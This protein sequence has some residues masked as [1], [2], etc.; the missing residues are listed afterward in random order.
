LYFIK[1]SVSLIEDYQQQQ[2]A[3]VLFSSELSES[4]ICEHVSLYEDHIRAAIAA[5]EKICGSCERFIEEQDFQLFQ[6]HLL[7]QFFHSESALSLRLD[8]CVLIKTDY[9]FC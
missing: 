8:S 1:I 7:L 6:D 3:T 2:T 9:L 5:T 4:C